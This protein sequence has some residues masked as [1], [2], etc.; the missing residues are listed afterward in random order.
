MDARQI[1]IFATPAFT[2]KAENILLISGTGAGR[3]HLAAAPG[4]EAVRRHGKRVHYF[5]TIEPVTP[6]RR[7]RQ[8]P[9]PVAS[10][11]SC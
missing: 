6:E 3:T 4:V 2:G 8:L 11:T 7:K 1:E 9:R 5:S 10:P